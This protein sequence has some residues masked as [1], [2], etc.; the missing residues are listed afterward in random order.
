MY[1][2]ALSNI[3]RKEA[4][5]DTHAT[6]PTEMNEGAALFHTG[7]SWSEHNLVL[8]VVMCRSSVTVLLRSS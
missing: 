6:D 5:V 2:P 1:T 7:Q 4:S 8:V 3:M